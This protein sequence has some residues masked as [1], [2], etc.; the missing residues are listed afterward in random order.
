MNEL[1]FWH[2]V[3]A[4]SGE[5]FSEIID[6]KKNE[7]LKYGYTIW[8]FAPISKNR[9]F[10]WRK[11]L[12]SINEID[13]LCSGGNNKAPGNNNSSPIWMKEYSIDMNTWNKLPENITSYHK[14]PNK[15]GIVASGFYVKEIN[16]KTIY[17]KR[18]KIWLD[19]DG[20]WINSEM[21][22]RGEFMIKSPEV[23][24]LTEKYSNIV[25]QLLLIKPF[26]VWLR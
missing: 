14:G 4:H 15:N 20:K 23:G 5:S 16:T 22:T 18:P 26:F 6:R 3:G 10:F 13:V 12:S 8:S 25:C 17:F 9:D 7:I 11:E 2:P 21:S 1:Y 24:S 19:Q